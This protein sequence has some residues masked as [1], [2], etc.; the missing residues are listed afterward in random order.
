[1]SQ[2]GG[3]ALILAAALLVSGCGPQIG[4]VDTQRVLNESV[5]ALE[6][7]K[8]LNDREKQ[9]VAEL[10]AL[11]GQVSPA[12]LTARRASLTTE[13]SQLRSDLENQL[14]QQLHDAAAQVA[15]QDGLRL[16]VIKNSS[17]LGGRDVTQQVIDRLK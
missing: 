4:I 15:R 5:K 10:A 6:Y 16:V 2:F 7:Q 13:L 11:N 14:N 8:Q 1:M 3:A 17:Y 9:M 12:E